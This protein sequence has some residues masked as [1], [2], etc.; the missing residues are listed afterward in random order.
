MRSPLSFFNRLKRKFPRNVF[1]VFEDPIRSE[2]FSAAHLERHGESLAKAQEVFS[3]ASKGVNLAARV[4]ENE[5]VLIEA[6]RSI[7]E[8][9]QEQ[10]AIT[11]AAEWLID[12]FHIVKEQL[13]DIRDHLPPE[14]Y[15]ELPKLSTGPLLGYPRI[16]GI[17]WAYVAHN[18]SLFDPDL[19]KRFVRSY[20]K[21]QPLTIGELWAISII[22][23]VVMIENLRRLAARIVGSQ[24]AR[25]EADK[26]ADEI[27]GL[28]GQPA[29]PTQEILKGLSRGPL[30]SGFAVQL[31]Q[32]LRFQEAEVTPVLS[33]LDDQLAAQGLVADKIV[34]EE[35]NSQTAANAT[36]RNIITSM[37]LMSAFDWRVFF[38]EV[39]L[40]DEILRLHPE[41]SSMD[42]MTRDRYRHG[43]ED[44]A[45]GAGIS[46]VDVA[47]AAL[48]KTE[49]VRA[50]LT[51]PPKPDDQKRTDLGFY[52]ISS[53][54]EELEKELGFKANARRRLL[55]WYMANGHFIYFGSINLL[56]ALF[57]FIC[58]RQGAP[59]SANAFLWFLLAFLGAFP[60]SEIAV[61]LVNRLTVGLLHPRRMPRLELLDGIPPH[62]KTFVV[63]P[64]L[65]FDE[66]EIV[67]Q[68]ERLEVHYLSN[69]EGAVY[70]A[71]LSDW[72]DAESEHHPGDW[73]LL[74]K[75]VRR[76]SDL[77]K[78]YGAVADGKNR[79]YIFHRI[80]RWNGGEG[81]WIGWE[82]KRGKLHEFN[83]FLRGAKDTSFIT[84]ND[85]A[86]S[87]KVEPLGD[88]SLDV[89]PDIRYVISL[90]ADTKLPQGAVA[91]LVGTLAHPL[92]HPE[93]DPD[94]NRVVDGYGILQ[95]RITPS[96]P[97]IQDNTIFQRLSSGPAGI[98]PYAS[99]VSDVYQDLFLE[100]SYTGKG[101]YDVDVFERVLQGRIPENRLLSH[102]LFEGT[103]ARCGLLSDVEFFEDFPS[104]C[105][106]AFARVH[107]WTR[108]DWQLLPWILGREGRA[109]PLIGRWKMVDNLRRSLS[110]PMTLFLLVAVFCIPQV[111]AS[112]WIALSLL[113]LGLPPLIPFFSEL[114]SFRKRIPFRRQFRPLIEDLI[115]GCSRFVLSLI[116]LP[117][118]AY[119]YL[120]AIGRALIRL[121]L[122][123]R[124]LLEWTTAAQVHSTST[125]TARGFL[126]TMFPAVAFVLIFCFLLFRYNPS[127]WGSALPLVILW[128]G[129]PFLAR[130]ISL[131]PSTD[132]LISL[133]DEDLHTLRNAARRIWRFFSVF[134]TAEDHYLPPDNFQETPTPILAHRSSPTNFGL[135]LLSVVSARDFGW[136]G[137]EEMVDR[138]EATI[139]TMNGLPRH[140]GHFFNW[141]ETTSGNPLEPRYI[142]SVDNGNLAGHLI[143]VAQACEEA[144]REPVFSANAFIG[145]QDTLRL[146]KI[147]LSQLPDDKRNLTVD[148]RQIAVAAGDL[149]ALLATRFEG[150]PDKL[151]HLEVLLS[152][153]DLLVDLA[154]TFAAERGEADHSEV[155]TWAKL[156]EHEVKGQVR[157]FDHLTPWAAFFIP[158]ELQA[159]RASQASASPWSAVETQLSM[160]V[161]LGQLASHCSSLI[162]DILKLKKDSK[163]AAQR[164]LPAYAE[165]LLEALETSLNSSA[166][167]SKR[168]NELAST[169][170]RLFNE[171]DFALLYD[172]LRKL[173]SIGYRLSDN[174]LDAGY[175]DLLASEARLLSF[176]AIAKGDVQASHWFHLGRTLIPTGK[177]A[178]LVSWSG[179]MFEYLMPYLVMNSPAASLLD[180]T[181][182][183]VVQSQILYGEKRSVPW[184]ISES[185]YHSRDIH[186]TYQYS[187]FGIPE[188][189]LKRGLG[190]DL[191]I[192]PYASFLAAMIDPASA[193]Q[194]LKQLAGLG[195]E[196]VFG[197]YEAV[198][199]TKERLPQGRS[200]VI[201]K[202]FMAHHQGMS[203]VSISNVIHSGIMRKRF[204]HEPIVQA[205]ELLL[206]ERT[207]RNILVANPR[208]E[209]IEVGPLHDT[210]GPTAR[211]YHSP[212]QSA[213]RTHLLSNGHYAVMVTAAG[214]GYS[215]FRDIS[216]TRWREDPTRDHWGNYIYLRDI[217]SEQIW[218]A[219]FQPTCVEPDRYEVVFTEDRARITR[220]D[221]GI[222]SQLEIFISPEDNAEVRRLTLTNN[223]PETRAIEVTS[224]AEVVLNTQGADIAHPT[225]SNLFVQTEYDPDTKSIL[226][227]RRPRSHKEAPVWMAHV[228]ATDPNAV[229]G[230]E[231]ETD[232]A[233][234]IGRGRNIR[235]PV[236]I[237]DGKP[238]SNT[239][240]SVLDPIVSL[241][242]RVRLEPGALAHVTYS[243]LIAP[244]R[245]DTL[246]LADK[247]RDVTTFERVSHLAWTQAQVVLH[248]LGIEPTEANL[249]QQ[250]ANRILYLDPS[251]RPS[252]DMLM[253]NELDV[254]GLWAHG[255]SGDHPII[256]ARID[257]IENRNIIRQLLRAHEYWG[258]KN[259]VVD[260]VILNEKSTSYV[261]DLQDSLESM[262]RDSS[263]SSGLYLPQSK[264]KVFILRA[265]LLSQ[266]DRDLLQTAARATL[267][268]R[269]GGLAEQ[270]K[271]MKRKTEGF[272]Y[273]SY[274]SPS[275][276]EYGRS[277]LAIPK[278]DFFNGLGGFAEQGR[279]YLIHLK[280]GQRTPAPWINVVAN[281]E[282][283]F[284]VSE[285]GAGST[286]S[287]NSRE[288]QITAWSNDP[289]SDPSGECFY[290]LDKDSGHY[291]SPTASPIRMDD[292]EYLTAH[293]QGY[294]RFELIHSE[295]HTRLTQFVSWHEPV[296][297]SKLVLKNTS[298]V[299]RRL[300]VTGYVEWVLGFSRSTTL[301][302]IVTEV[303]PDTTA[304]FA[305]NPWN[306]E[307]GKRISFATF[308]GGNDSLSGDRT[309][310]LGRNGNTEEPTALTHGSYLFEKVGAG[311][312][313][314]AVLQ[315]NLVIEPGQEITV[316]FLL[317]QAESRE[318]ARR[319][320]NAYPTKTVDEAL[321]QV[322]EKWNEILTR[323]QVETPD[324]AMNLMLNRWLLYQTTSCRLWARAGFY[325]AG[326]AYGFRDQLQDSMALIWAKPDMTRSQ[327]LLASSRQFSEGDVQHWWHTPS[328][329]G[330]RTR[331]SDDL[332]WMPYVVSHYLKITR[333]ASLLDEE[334]PFLKAPLLLPDQEDF[335]STPEVSGETASI[336][337]HCARALDRSLKVGVHGLPLIGGGDWND[338]MNRVGHEGKGES[339]WLAWFLY[340][341][342][343]EFSKIAEARG[344]AKRARRWA[345]HATRL[346]SAVEKEAW[347]GAWY[348]RAFFDDGTPLGASSNME[349]RI[350]SI[351]QTWAV[352]SGAA[353]RARAIRAMESVEDFLVRTADKLVLLLTPP[354]DKTPLDPGYIKGYLPGVRENGGQYSHAAIWCILAYSALNNGQR[355]VELFSML[356]P[357]N[358]SHSRAG[359]HRYRVE[360]YVIAADIYSE[361]PYVGRGGWT[362]Y[363]GS[364]SLMY[365]AGIDS[366]L[367][368][369]LTGNKL[370]I[371]PHIHPEWKG[372][373]IRYRHGNTHYEI[374]VKNSKG[375][376]SGISRITLDGKSVHEAGAAIELVD[377]GFRHKV[378]VEIS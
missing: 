152:K 298:R 56:T 284:H 378:D 59:Y 62:L 120:D 199:F 78:K 332:L 307:F 13:K 126:R 122:T 203:L 5:H 198:D 80:R 140:H 275:S 319:L 71:L 46:E 306:P 255:I 346:K 264:G 44:L 119:I 171:M 318:K 365:R 144:L 167:I 225:F 116:L 97:A 231:F 121:I 215:R 366:I 241:R 247:I 28:G 330:V 212:G 327:I 175:Y 89:P 300:S 158:Q 310:F 34:P 197:F 351:A 54:R 14:Y 239:V 187:T 311:L 87:S 339:V 269:Q 11:P 8:T 356:N 139:R 63:V 218:S 224:Y 329:R 347:D 363:T 272:L 157:D 271:R 99:A 288:N 270:V 84:P 322:A 238:L 235:N 375:L 26:V 16:Y 223:G 29:R 73:D 142:S 21:V 135:Y 66:A 163:N 1:A 261:Q 36:V 111:N 155:L 70:F 324:D 81:K 233:R 334:A 95:P 125:L 191:V 209:S 364:A 160:R 263:V 222:T 354:F 53:G 131:P 220:E 349:C 162:K 124:Y 164:L 333:D 19:L 289:V 312:D 22:L 200:K 230:I 236:S 33:W 40:V 153:S 360:P 88:L 290:I 204:H 205:A 150:V 57:L 170:R 129:S 32:R 182:R 100:G 367:G 287:L 180:Q 194:N 98:D 94:L 79:F 344:E 246:N 251:L 348:R 10:R 24:M 72:T 110:A 145:T 96:L 350:D 221:E 357:I 268:A 183:L 316:V 216:I 15:R 280:N 138:L 48:K 195:A 9:I 60:A 227:T 92:N 265:D 103:F 39:S 371:E 77:N 4:A 169:C 136:I 51:E 303:D 257:D 362:W 338:G 37:R 248:Y 286:W 328:G 137:V 274:L 176:I 154:R 184:G 17:A 326:G 352:L 12:N 341:N 91:K 165:S 6:Y 234:F 177:G 335:Y 296:K 75:A 20:Q 69:P 242:T 202:A 245:E 226:A 58:I 83:R 86:S 283:G 101:I 85:V 64:M 27:L 113:S 229:G 172:P 355:A 219:G 301:P 49:M 353:D 193:V 369:K 208:G 213:P 282:F 314:C 237:V 260:L 117:Q 161:P 3:G 108:G 50:L 321:R 109:I 18:D 262:V 299:R 45:R 38:E 331:I 146:L 185:A 273:S 315:K 188:L 132:H 168:L 166:A 196:G 302:F 192:S 133:K 42:F 148:K 376:S 105:E 118:H 313:P 30:P 259:L 253:R 377:D 61:T 65:L 151:G 130:Q 340:F 279:E 67:H 374:E 336:F 323:I 309:E 368:F 90:D 232:R 243:T 278:L 342:L 189:G 68:V 325:Q 267:V 252:S 41:Y 373:K 217:D 256:L 134:V 156:I 285:S 114:F 207:P 211:R 370:A 358:H 297:I 361:T 149:D 104:H 178:A 343:M 240:G 266:Q 25:K 294:S 250:L 320:I 35:H 305:H 76:I 179:S 147:S 74:N 277:A 190:K 345:E 254:T 201:V 55:R 141:Y 210:S 23:R 291:W 173:F 31:V 292:A 127:L 2:M 115:L 174:S 93:I 7:A 43:L 52:L 186:L 47:R 107:R 281:P 276:A 295:I 228:I 159:K 143:A 304:I 128:L 372:Y 214:A 308:S 258:M 317:G 244:T 123:K 337:E 293:G 249:F 359:V 102:D 106:V 112:P 206:Q 181:C 82:R